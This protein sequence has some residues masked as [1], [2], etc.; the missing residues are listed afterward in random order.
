MGNYEQAHGC[1][2]MRPAIG[3]RSFR[4]P[5]GLAKACPGDS[6]ALYQ[7]HRAKSSGRGIRHLAVAQSESK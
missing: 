2:D 5:A 7:W 3:T 4:I 1:A 6:N